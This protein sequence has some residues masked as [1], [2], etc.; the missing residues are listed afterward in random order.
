MEPK[1][2]NLAERFFRSQAFGPLVVVIVL[3]AFFAIVSAGSGFFSLE[4]TAAWLNATA[5][6]GIVAIPVALLMIAGEFDLS[7]GSLVGAGATTVGLMSGFFGLP[8]WLSFV[9]AI[10]IGCL[11]GLLNGFLVTRTRLPS[12]IVSLGT[13]LIVVGLGITICEALTHATTISVLVGTDPF[14]PIFNTKFGSFGITI[15]WWILIV[16][17]AAW[18][19]RRTRFGNWI[20]ATGGDAE[21]ARRSGVMT[22]RVKVTLFVCTAVASA[23]VGAMQAVKFST[24]DPTLGAGYVF[25]GPIV[26]VIGGVLLTGG[27]GSILGVVCGLLIYG[28]SSA[29]LFYAGWDANLTQVLLGVLL[30][31]AVLS[32][33]RLRR[34]ALAPP[35]GIRNTRAEVEP[36]APGRTIQ[37]RTTQKKEAS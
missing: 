23:F 35:R 30:I 29:G 12:F 33:N 9:C 5:D 27:Y 20:F 22:D 16:A 11:F 18:V 21:R 3:Y 15:V 13:N 32:N 31:V 34:I 36:G 10:L 14:A 2:R 8:L 7:I 1:P 28:I 4:G 25:E 37:K 24:S 6:I 17:I 26:V 19:L